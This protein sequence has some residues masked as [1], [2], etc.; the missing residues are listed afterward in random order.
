MDC[1]ARIAFHLVVAALGITSMIGAC[2][3]KGPLYLPPEPVAEVPAAEIPAADLG[4]G[5]D[6][7]T[8]A[9]PTSTPTGP[10]SAPPTSPAAP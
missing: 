1:R 10:T 5:A 2:G 3:Q 9:A 4:P 7:P 8:D 6:V